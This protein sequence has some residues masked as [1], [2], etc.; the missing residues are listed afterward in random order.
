MSGLDHPFIMDDN[1][2]QGKLSF[3]TLFDED[4]QIFD[5]DL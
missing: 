1:S 5:H 3:S 4:F 2:Y